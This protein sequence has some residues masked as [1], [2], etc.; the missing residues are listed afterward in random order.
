M[1]M[2]P[3][4]STPV[5][6]RDVAKAAGVSVA[7]ASMA[8]SE[9]PNIHPQ[10]RELVRRASVQLGYQRPQDRTFEAGRR[11]GAKAMRHFGLLV[12]ERNFDDPAYAGTLRSVNAALARRRLRAQ[13]LA[14]E[15]PANDR[16]GNR[17]AVDFARQLDGLLITGLV[18]RPLVEAI[19]ATNVHAVVL[20]HTVNEAQNAQR[21]QGPLLPTVIHDEQRMA[22][23]AVRTLMERGHRRIAFVCRQV[24]PGLFQD[25]WME[26]YQLEHLSRGVAIDSALIFTQG[27]TNTVDAEGKRAAMIFARMANPPTAFI[28]PYLNLAHAFFQEMRNLGSP[29]NPADAITS[30]S[31]YVASQWGMQNYPRIV[32]NETEMTEIAVDIVE[33]WHISGKRP[34]C[35]VIVPFVTCNLPPASGQ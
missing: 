24:I 26:G 20:G 5:R 7:T 8:L 34:Q 19:V 30:G 2:A 16:Q 4:R 27:S 18:R 11:M 3:T 33:Q 21:D 10:T 28:I 35:E 9:H 12:M 1:V 13:I 15:N 14:I 23:C 31:Q 32:G 29:V 17:Q 22:R 6:L 25:R